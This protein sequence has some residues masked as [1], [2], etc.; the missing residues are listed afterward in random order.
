VILLGYKI[1]QFLQEIYGHLISIGPSNALFSKLRFRYYS[2]KLKKASTVFISGTGF[3]IMNP[4]NVSIGKEVL[5]NRN[6][7]LGTLGDQGSPSEII[8]GDYCLFGMNVVIIAGNHPTG[9][10]AVP[11]RLQD[12]IPSKIVISD[13]CWIG[14]NVTISKSVTIGKGSVIGAN[15]VVTHDIPPYSVAV[16]A[17]ARVIKSRISK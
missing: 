2:P 10:V 5:F 17:P 7:F 4:E 13:D 12:S 11:F 8:I 6:V 1:K 15:S 16:G 9:N 14:A 3:Y